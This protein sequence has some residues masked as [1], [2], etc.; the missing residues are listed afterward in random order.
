MSSER[1]MLFSFDYR[2][3]RSFRS[4]ETKKPRQSRGLLP[5]VQR[6]VVR[7]LLLD[8]LTDGRRAQIA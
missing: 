4:F 7:H 5:I 8:Q 6:L 2:S 3:I 1:V